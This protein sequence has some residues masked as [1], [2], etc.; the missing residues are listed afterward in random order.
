[1][2][3]VEDPRIVNV[4]LNALETILKVGGNDAKESGINQYQIFIDQS[5]GKELIENL[6]NH[7]SNELNKQALKI[8]RI[9]F[10]TTRSTLTGI[11]IDFIVDNIS[12]FKNLESIPSELK[13]KIYEQKFK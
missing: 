2:L 3:H 9:Y 5:Q 12:I 13:N 4:A 1:M 8:W 10:S 7:P 11:C 6:L